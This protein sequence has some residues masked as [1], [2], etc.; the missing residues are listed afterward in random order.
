[1]VSVFDMFGR[2]CFRRHSNGD[3]VIS[4]N[5]GVYVVL[6]GDHATKVRL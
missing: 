1:M 6:V 2:L 4:L 5:S 3:E